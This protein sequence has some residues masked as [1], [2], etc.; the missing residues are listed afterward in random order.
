MDSDRERDEFRRIQL[1]LKVE[2][3]EGLVSAYQD[4]IRT[5]IKRLKN[6]YDLLGRISERLGEPEP[7]ELS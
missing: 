1:N 5:Y 3:V 2:R 6:Y 7:E 4:G